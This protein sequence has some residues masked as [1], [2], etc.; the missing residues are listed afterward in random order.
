M[1]LKI[2][3]LI[4]VVVVIVRTNEENYCDPSLCDDAITHT[5][6]NHY[7]EF[8]QGCG[9]DPEIVVMT[10]SHKKLILDA[11][12]HFRNKIASGKLPG[13]APAARMPALRWNEDLAYIAGI[14]ARSCTEDNDDC[15]NT[16]LFRNVGQ[17]I[18]YDYN[19]EPAHNITAV[20]KRILDAWYGEHKLGNQNHIKLLTE[21]TL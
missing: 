19:G 11:H 13:F 7:L 20:I 12:N 8:A 18:G 10:P 6:C 15:R 16:R 17:N 3:L 1:D 5:A 21:E 2:L 4:A 9:D 14:H